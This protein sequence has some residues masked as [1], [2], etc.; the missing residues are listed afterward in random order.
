MLRAAFDDD[1]KLDE[2]EMM[3]DGVA[4]HQQLLRALGVRDCETVGPR[5]KRKRKKQ[6]VRRARPLS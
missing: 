1:G 6:V 4:V 2:L 5:R 3:F